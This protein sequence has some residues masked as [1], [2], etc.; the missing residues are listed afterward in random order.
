MYILALGKQGQLQLAETTIRYQLQTIDK[1]GLLAR[2]ENNGLG[3]FF[4]RR[5]TPDG[6]GMDKFFVVCSATNG[7]LNHYGLVNF[8]LLQKD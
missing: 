4:G 6:D 3:K 8:S 2:K 1:T 7:L 5:P